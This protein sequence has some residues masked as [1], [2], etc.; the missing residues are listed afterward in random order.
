MKLWKVKFEIAFQPFK[1]SFFSNAIYKHQTFA[2]VQST[3]YLERCTAGRSRC[4]V[5]TSPPFTSPAQLKLSPD[6]NFFR[7]PDSALSNVL[8][9]RLKRFH[10]RSSKNVCRV[11]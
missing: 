7:S 2:S 1:V 4:Y 9:C 8:F 5:P 11:L 3:I 10:V 6:H